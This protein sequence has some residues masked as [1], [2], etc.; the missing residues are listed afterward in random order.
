MAHV[1]EPFRG[2]KTGDVV[3]GVCGGDDGPTLRGIFK[4]GVVGRIFSSADGRKSC[5][6]RIDGAWGGVSRVWGRDTVNGGGVQR[7]RGGGG[8]R[9]RVAGCR[10][11]KNQGVSTQCINLQPGEGNGRRLV[12]MIVSDEE[13]TEVVGWLRLA[14]DVEHRR[15]R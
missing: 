14:V 13:Q 1:L 8:T 12:V 15:R 3:V 7:A 9:S 11:G 2:P 4:F 10:R 5:V 6:R